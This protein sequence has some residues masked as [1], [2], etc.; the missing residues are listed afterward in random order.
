MALLLRP[1]TNTNSSM[2]AARHSS[3]AYWISG[4]STTVSISLGI[5]L[6]AGKNRVPRPATGNTALRIGFMELSLRRFAA[7][8]GSIRDALISGKPYLVPYGAATTSAGTR[9]DAVT[10]AHRA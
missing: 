9:L 1:V 2:P 8:G 3:I 6:V 4:R 7:F 5:A 10:S